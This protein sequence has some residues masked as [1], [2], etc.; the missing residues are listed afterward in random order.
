MNGAIRLVGKR[1]FQVFGIYA[2]LWHILFVVVVVEDATAGIATWGGVLGA[3]AYGLAHLLVPAR[4]HGGAGIQQIA[5][6]GTGIA[7][8]T[9]MLRANLR[10]FGQQ[11]HTGGT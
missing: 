6:A 9:W 2:L 4:S 1:A 3:Y 8:I 5:L 7:V 11:K 10:R